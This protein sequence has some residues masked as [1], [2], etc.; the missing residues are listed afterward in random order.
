[1]ARLTNPIS[2][3]K[4]HYPV[5][6]IGSGYG[7][8]IAASRLARAGQ[9]VCVLERG[10]EFQPGEYPD[11]L[12]EARRQIQIDTP[13]GHEGPPTALFDFRVNDDIHV[14]MGCGLGGTSLINANVALAPDPRVFQHR[15]W[16][17]SFRN[18]VATRLKEAFERAEEMLKPV[19]FPEHLPIPPKLAALTRAA[20][21]GETVR[22]APINVNFDLEGPNHVGVVQHTCVR[23]GDCVSGCNYGAKNT[24]IMNYLPD[25]KNFG[26]EIFTEVEVHSLE[27]QNGR[28][29]I[30]YQVLYPGPARFGA[31]E[32]F[33]TA[34]IVILGAGSLGSTEI[35]LRSRDAGLPVSPML[36]HRFTGN[37]DVVAFGYNTEPEI[38]GVGFGERRPEKMEPVG[39]CITGVIDARATENL[40]DGMVIEEGAIPGA[41]GDLV[42]G[43]LA[44]SAGLVGRPP[45]LDP[46]AALAA[47]GRFVHGFLG[48]HAGAPRHTITYLVNAHDDGNGQLE[49]DARA[50]VRVHWPGV[51]RQ[52]IF[53]RI[54]E[55]LRQATQ[56]LRGTHVRNPVWIPLLRHDLVTVHPLGGCVM[57]DDAAHGVVNHRGQVFSGATG[58]SV[59]ENLYVCDGAVIPRPLGVNP[60]LTISAVA[61][62]CAALLAADRGWK[63]DYHLPS[64]PRAPAPPARVGIRFT[65]RMTGHFSNKVLDDFARGAEQGRQDSSP[66]AF[67]LTIVADDLDRFLTHDPHEARLAGTITA[68]ALSSDPLTVTRGIFHLLKRDPDQVNARRMCYG[69]PAVD[70]DGH[71]YYVDGFKVI[72]ND[73]GL[74]I[75]PDTTTL[76]ITIHDG[77]DASGRVVGRGILHIAIPDF[78]KQVTTLEVT[79]AETA[80]QR[81][82]AEFAFARFFGLELYQTYAGSFANPTVFDPQA[83][84]RKR[85]TL[86]A[87]EPE[88]HPVRTADG[89]ELR[90]TRFHGGPKGPVI[91]APGFGTST[92]A[93]V[94]DTIDTNLTEFLVAHGYDVWLF[95]YRASPDLPAA[96]EE[97][98]LDEIARLDY[99]AAVAKVLAETKAESVQVMGHCVASVTLMMALLHGLRGVRTAICSQFMPH[100]EQPL[101]QRL[102]AWSHLAELL[103]GLGIHR[104]TPKF[105]TGAKW[106]TWLFDVLLRLY[107]TRQ[108][109]NNPVCR[110]ILF[111][112]GEVYRHDRLNAATHDAIH[113]MFGVGNMRAFQHLTR[114]I[115]KRRAVTFAGKD[116]YMPNIGQLDGVRVMLLQGALNGIFQPQGSARTYEWLIAAI[117]SAKVTRCVIENY[118]HMDCFI[119]RHAARDVFPVILEELEKGP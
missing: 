100:V 86:R 46:A 65:E 118:G 57:A 115:R 105:E 54:D 23:C 51:G 47:V 59:Y 56:T 58:T 108:V 26:A 98:S 44:L 92:L 71:H 74:D 89:L 31:E 30:R 2:D 9:Q 87:P 113:E 61:E 15:A 19:P 40:E 88:V 24:L 33:L 10:R 5:V 48:P 114:M 25:A 34:D 78:L 77:S 62:R 32:R 7:G 35:L 116:E 112:Y 55:R 41:L 4:D 52:P 1:M 45:T 84:P 11:T 91:L 80:A 17:E 16:P 13:L 64:A 82:D 63:V 94:I 67:T 81:R 95:D 37:G 101:T 21:P 27:R 93:F 8:A 99:P 111:M 85:R 36:G 43:G 29:L 103:H 68:P 18:D 22:R 53:R 39:P 97:F 69:M 38:R 104:M 110:R 102:K 49:L 60:L 12:A 106:H 72:R 14:V 28:W 20:A 75:W 90:L 50:R 117:G 3:L 119:G 107:P 109:C 42:P 79:N 96:R 6:V 73:P 70:K 66:F 83:P 76:Y